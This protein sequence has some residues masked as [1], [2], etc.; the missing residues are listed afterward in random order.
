MW[1]VEGVFESSDSPGFL[2]VLETRTCWVT[3]S[4]EAGSRSR[5]GRNGQATPLD[6]GKAC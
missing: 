1:V 6:K 3:F 4:Q 2:D 5:M